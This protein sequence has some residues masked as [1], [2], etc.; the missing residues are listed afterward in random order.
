MVIIIKT[1]SKKKQE[2]K[3]VHTNFKVQE[4]LVGEYNNSSKG[5]VDKTSFYIHKN[6]AV[7]LMAILSILR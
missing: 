4:I 5:I 2:I 7:D 1:F 3:V 6:L